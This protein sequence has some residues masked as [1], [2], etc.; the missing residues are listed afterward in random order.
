MRLDGFRFRYLGPFGSE[1]VAVEGLV[2][3]LNVLADHNERGKSSLLRG[4]QLFLLQ[5]HTSWGKRGHA[6]KRDD[7]PTTGEIDFTHDG[8]AYRLIK[9]YQRGKDAQLIDRS[10]GAVLAKKGE[11]DERMAAI[12]GTIDKARGPSGLLWIEQGQ[13]MDA[14]QDD[15]RLVASKVETEMSVLVGGDRARDYLART[16]AALGELLTATGRPR[17]GGPLKAAE[18]ALVRIEA[19]LLD[20]ERRRDQTRQIGRELDRA[21]SALAALQAQDDTNADVRIAAVRDE[22]DAALTA[23]AH[24]E[25]AKAV[26]QRL[27]AETERANDRLTRHLDHV[28]AYDDAAAGMADENAAIAS[29]DARRNELKAQQSRIDADLRELRQEQARLV[30]REAAKARADRLQE[31]QIAL[32]QLQARLSSLDTTLAA[33]TEQIQARD[34]LPEIDRDGLDQ[35]GA[36]EATIDRLDRA[37]SGVE[38]TLRLDLL[39]GAQ[40]EIDGKPIISGSVTLDATTVL[41]LPG[42]GYI[43]LDAPEA[44]ALKIQRET[45]RSDIEARLHTIGVADYAAAADAVRRRV[46]IASDLESLEREIA[47]IAPQGRDRLIDHQQVL[48]RDIAALE[49]KLN[50][51]EPDDC[52]TD[53]DRVA[54]DIAQQSAQRIVTEEALQDVS[55]K[56]EGARARL[57]AHRR[58][59]AAL[60]ADVALDARGARQSELAASA[61]TAQARLETAQSDLERLTDSV[62]TDPDILKASL[63]RLIQVRDNRAAELEELQRRVVELQARRSGVLDRSDPDTEANALMEQR[64]TLRETIKRHRQRAGALSLLRDT[65]TEAQLR[66]QAEYT[67]PVRR[68][69]APLL[70]RVIDGADLSLSET[71]GPQGLLRNGRD[72]TLDRLSGGTREQIAI[73]TRLAFA[74]LLARGGQPCPVILDDA[75]VHADDDRRARMF[76]VLTYVGSGEDPLQLLYL[77][78]HERAARELGGHRLRFDSWPEN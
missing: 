6:V 73:L 43:R 28:R 29:H 19:D 13:S 71:L 41:T 21:R 53:P 77:S 44:D 3:G 20:A 63:N 70:A 8:T 51:A 27:Q 1:G 50:D 66:L 38:V 14:V 31:R 67:A 60:P 10:T 11:A 25:T 68:E 34:A 56:L 47:R 54:T 32:G 33:R 23:R 58:A 40:A 64:D 78:C 48:E 17:V 5:G 52:A 57:D 55:G 30:E 39:P 42:A 26:Q 46:D 16:E 75:L 12:M 7:G 37:L 76:D 59:M 65:L 62:R 61:A 2:P 4:L 35:L 49:T 18:D 15:D 69:L 72:D 24:W 22:L 9:T 36:L 74:R 45:A